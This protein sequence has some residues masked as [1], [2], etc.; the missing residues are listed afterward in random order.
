MVSLFFRF[1]LVTWSILNALQSTFE[2]VL[3][4][5]DLNNLYALIN[6]WEL[7][8]NLACVSFDF[9]KNTVSL[10]HDKKKKYCFHALDV[11]IDV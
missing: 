2:P 9:L 5:Y 10:T 1:A 6:Q 11:S 3:Y 4:F 8:Q 7:K